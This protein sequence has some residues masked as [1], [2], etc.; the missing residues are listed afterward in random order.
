MSKDMMGFGEKPLKMK[1]SNEPVDAMV[2]GRL[3]HFQSKL[4]YRWSQYLDFLLLSEEIKDFFYEFHTFYFDGDKKPTEYT[5]DFLIR[6]KD[7]SFEYHETKGALS[8]YD[9]KKFKRMFDERPNVKITLIFW[10]KPKI[11]V[12]KRRL[13]ERYCHRIIYNAK[14]M[15]K[16]IPMD[17]S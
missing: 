5:P 16:N 15:M 2:N 13:L 6:N 1:Y 14:S 17:M 9:M 11:S 8:A 10:S 3:C 7:N 4:E 12:N